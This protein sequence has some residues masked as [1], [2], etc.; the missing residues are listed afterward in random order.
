MKFEWDPVK[1]EKNKTSHGITFE[2]AS[3]VFGDPLSLTISD[4]KHSHDEQ[5]YIT[6]G[7]SSS[8]RT[9]VVIHT[10]RGDD[11]RIVSARPAAKRE[12]R[13]YEQGI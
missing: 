8:V 5:R 7:V 13:D 2:E 10:D 1:A 6:I 9:L 11:V 4:P 12:R 3:T